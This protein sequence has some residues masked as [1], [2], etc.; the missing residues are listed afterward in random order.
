MTVQLYK[1]TGHRVSSTRPLPER[2]AYR[3]GRSE[4][5]ALDLPPVRQVRHVYKPIQPRLDLMLA[6]E[7]LTHSARPTFAELEAL[8]MAEG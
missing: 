3:S 6:V 4:V 2:P 8:I 1:P 7:A 5:P